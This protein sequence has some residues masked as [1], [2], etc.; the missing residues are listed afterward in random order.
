MSIRSRFEVQLIGGRRRGPA[1]LRVLGIRESCC[2]VSHIGS[3][4]HGAHVLGLVLDVPCSVPG[5]VLVQ[6]PGGVP[7][8]DLV[9]FWLSVLVGWCSGRLSLLNDRDLDVSPRLE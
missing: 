1:T 5:D 6:I 2:H 8:R 4:R 9:Q 3:A 7:W